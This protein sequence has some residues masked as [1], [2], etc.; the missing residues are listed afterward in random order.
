[1]RRCL[2]KD[3]SERFATATG[4]AAALQRCR[5]VAEWNEDEAAV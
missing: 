4:V 3:P 1:M 2:A 5:S